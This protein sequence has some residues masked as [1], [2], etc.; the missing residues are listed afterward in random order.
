MLLVLYPLWGDFIQNEALKHCGLKNDERGIGYEKERECAT[1]KQ[2]ILYR[3]IEIPVQVRHDQGEVVVKNGVLIEGEQLCV[4][5]DCD[6]E[7][8]PFVS[9]SNHELVHMLSTQY[10]SLLVGN[11]KEGVEIEDCEVH[12]SNCDEKMLYVCSECHEMHADETYICQVCD[13]ESLRIVLE[14]E[15]IN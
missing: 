8:Y 2:T 11:W 12:E 13:C 5:Y 3:I 1:L 15:L 14:S 4:I 6:G 9:T 7:Y 10:L